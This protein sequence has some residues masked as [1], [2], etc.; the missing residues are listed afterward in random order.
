[1]PP[2][3]KPAFGFTSKR[4]CIEANDESIARLAGSPV[5]VV[6]VHIPATTP[7]T[8]SKVM[9]CEGFLKVLDNVRR[10]V[11]ERQTRR[12]GLPILVP[13]FTKCHENLSEME[14]WYD[15]WIRAVGSA[16]HSGPKR[17]CRPDP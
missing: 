10:F 11:A 17:L 5:D 2:G 13:I 9:G 1:M 12:T 16:R 6:S 4:I 3:W 14:P 15:Q 8:Y 7:Q